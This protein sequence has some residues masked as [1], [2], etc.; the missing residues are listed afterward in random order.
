MQGRYLDPM[1]IT[2]AEFQR[3]FYKRWCPK[4][5]QDERKREFIQLAQGNMTVT[6]Y[7]AHFTHLSFFA[8]AIV[9]NETEG[10][11]HF[12]ASL[13]IEIRSHLVLNHYIDFVSL[14]EAYRAEQIIQEHKKL[15]EQT[16][17]RSHFSY[18]SGGFYDKSLKRGG[19]VY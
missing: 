18:Q 11:D 19:T 12:K 2:W 10:C 7:E 9:A 8:P 4:V 16:S 13:H 5:Y 15:E 14:V 3:E 17:K 6:E 1:V